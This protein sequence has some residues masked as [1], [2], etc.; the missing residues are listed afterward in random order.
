MRYMK[1]SLTPP[2]AREQWD[3]HIADIAEDSKKAEDL[4]KQLQEIRARE[5]SPEEQG[6]VIDEYRKVVEGTIKK[7]REFRPSE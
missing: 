1:E 5:G 2:T 3:A 4:I 6:V 7:I